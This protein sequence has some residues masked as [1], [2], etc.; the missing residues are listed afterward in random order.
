[1]DLFFL[2]NESSKMFTVS[3][4][5][6]NEIEGTECLYFVLESLDWFVDITGRVTV[7]IE[8]DDSK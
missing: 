5:D 3:S 2:P 4:V 7:C 6:D 8:L 1:M